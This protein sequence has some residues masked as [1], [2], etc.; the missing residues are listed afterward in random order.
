[1]PTVPEQTAL[2]VLELAQAGR[3]AEV[4]E[5]FVPQ[6]RAMVA[7]EA[8]QTAWT[9]ELGRQGA[10]TSVGAAL[11]EPTGAGPVVV[12]VP[13]ICERGGFTLVAQVNEAGQLGGLQLAPPAA[14]QPTAPW[15]PPG[16]A[17]PGRF[18]EQEVT[19]GPEPVAVSGTLSIPHG[20]GPWP[21]VV[22]LAGSGSLDRDETVGRN[23]PLKDIAWGLASRGVAVLRFDKVTYAHAAMVKDTRDFTLTDEYL[24]HATAAIALL[25]QHPGV[26]A[27]RVFVLGHSLGGTVAPRV[28]EAAP[29]VAGLIV[30][31]GGA[32]PL[33]RVIIR[34]TRYLAS[35]N[36]A[37]AAGSQP[38]I[39][40]LTAMADTVDSPGLSPTTPASELPLGAPAS[41]WLDLRGYDAPAL[42]AALGTPMLILQGGRDYQA[43]VEDDLARWRA[44][45]D[46]RPGVTIR[47]YPAFNHLFVAGSGPS[48]PAEYEPAQHVDPA[49]IDD[50]AAWLDGNR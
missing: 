33:H 16:Y 50:I 28:A 45:L 19:L 30:M 22:L 26:A 14:A 17:D 42:A 38:V 31:A 32:A 3:F 7:P 27:Q 20:A 9:A 5:L 44:A 37:G 34:Q 11:S 18:A 1:M 46:G 13:V 36:P 8:L 49:V 39:D 12:K 2:T 29:S 35:L 4:R 41:Y 24:P 25:Q 43:T 15:E 6:L 47:V 10:V 23:K 48:T 40:A 21:G